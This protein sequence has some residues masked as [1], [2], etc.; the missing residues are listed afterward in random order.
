[1]VTSKMTKL[2][3]GGSKN[4]ETSARCRCGQSEALGGVSSEQRQ[5]KSWFIAVLAILTALAVVSLIT[6]RS[7]SDTLNLALF[8]FG[9]FM[10]L[11]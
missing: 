6:G 11:W 7:I 8:G 4:P 3:H 5:K 2:G 10:G 1:M 9:K